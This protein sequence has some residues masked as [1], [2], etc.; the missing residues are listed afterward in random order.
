M[1]ILKEILIII[2]VLMLIA[3]ANRVIEGNV[4]YASV[5]G[6]TKDNYMTYEKK[7]PDAYGYNKGECEHEYLEG[8]EYFY[9]EYYDHWNVER[10]YDKSLIPKTVTNKSLVKKYCRKHYKT[11]T[12]KYTNYKP[13]RKSKKYVFVETVKSISDGGKHG[14]TKDGYYI[15]YNKSV[16]KGKSVTSYL[17]YNPKT[18]YIDDVV[19]VVDNQKI[20]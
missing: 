6:I 11:R 2:A 5:E 15:R 19:A 8:E 9:D 1:K 7:Y 3:I 20:R 12:I 10:V 16:K 17:I 4:C 14:H 13:W 18:K